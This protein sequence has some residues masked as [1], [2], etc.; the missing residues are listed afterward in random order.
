MGKR[1]KNEKKIIW[2]E[3]NTSTYL[4][5]GKTVK[6]TKKAGSIRLHSISFFP[7]FAP[8]NK[9]RKPDLGIY[10]VQYTNKIH[11]FHAWGAAA[12]I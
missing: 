4:K 10:T 11:Y 1:R 9:H 3:I 12:L 8:E 7:N 5:P 2:T 6:V